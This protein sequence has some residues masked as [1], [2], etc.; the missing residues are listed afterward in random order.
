MVI[1]LLSTNNREQH[2]TAQSARV[3]PVPRCLLAA[4]ILPC[5]LSRSSVPP[6]SLLLCSLP[7]SFLSFCSCPLS[8]ITSKASA[9]LL[10]CLLPLSCPAQLPSPSS[11]PLPSSA[12]SSTRLLLCSSPS[13][14][15][16]FPAFQCRARHRVLLTLQHRRC[17]QTGQSEQAASWT[18]DTPTHTSTQHKINTEQ[19][20]SATC[21]AY[22]CPR[23]SSRAC[24][25]CPSVCALCSSGVV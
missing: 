19:S 10:S 17:E 13:A 24:V 23:R 22:T 6:A 7:S 12:S 9:L 8:P 4:P 16:V 1:V 21:A 18:G 5:L 2:S 3:L 15:P 14:F 11:L 25:P 20:V